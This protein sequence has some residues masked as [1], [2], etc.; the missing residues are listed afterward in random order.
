MRC[1][2]QIVQPY[3]I[4]IEWDAIGRLEMIITKQT[5]WFVI[6]R[7]R[8]EISQLTSICQPLCASAS[9]SGSVRGNRKVGQMG[10]WSSVAR[11]HRRSGFIP[12]SASCVLSLSLSFSFFFSLANRIPSVPAAGYLLIFCFFL[13][14]YGLGEKKDGGRS[15]DRSKWGTERERERER[16]GRDASSG[17]LYR[18]V[19][20]V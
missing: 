10:G 6:M 5:S 19:G 14:S 15:I 11:S 13:T 16:D 4:V 3:L 8:T 17:R 2:N 12:V 20:L 7:A 1:R 9:G 18:S